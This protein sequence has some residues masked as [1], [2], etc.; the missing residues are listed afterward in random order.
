MGAGES[1]VP[2]S[3]LGDA[4]E[5]QKQ[6][7]HLQVGFDLTEIVWQIHSREE[8]EETDL[9]EGALPLYKIERWEIWL[10]GYSGT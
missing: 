3:L 7:G 1:W 5:K 2:A 9:T 8:K 6:A 10:F 4:T